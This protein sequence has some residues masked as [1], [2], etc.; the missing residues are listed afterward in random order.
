MT[1]PTDPT[2]T[3]SCPGS[4]TVPCTVVSRTTAI[5][6]QVG[7]TKTPFKLKTAGRVVGWQITLSSPSPAQIKYFDGK[8]GGSAEAA[9]AI[10]H[11]VKGL[12]YKLKYQS[13]VEHLQR[14]FGQTATFALPT[15]VAVIPGDVI[16]LAVPT[17]AP[18]LEL[19]AGPKTA[20][21]ASRGR[22][23]CG[24]VT[25][26]TTQTFAGGASEYWCIYRTALITYGAVEI[27]TP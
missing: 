14:Y 20:W 4:A 17:W 22:G 27:S 10:I 26:Q 23:K 2:A 13:P 25:T 5:Q 15:S 7:N 9:L 3:E 24:D 1:D 6:E 19:K 21:R 11:Q 18:A 8:E 12:D 16:A